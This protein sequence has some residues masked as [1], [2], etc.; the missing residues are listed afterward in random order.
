VSRVHPCALAG[1]ALPDEITTTTGHLAVL[2]YAAERF[3]GRLRVVERSCTEAE[4]A[5]ARESDPSPE[6]G[7]L[8]AIAEQHAIPV[9]I[10]SNNSEAAVR[11]FLERFEWARMIKT[12]ACRTPANIAQMKADPHL[13]TE[14]ARLVGIDPGACV[15]VG[16]SV[17]DVVAARAAGVSTVGLGKSP[18]R[19]AQLRAAGADAVLERGHPQI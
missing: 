5:C 2:R 1:V 18:R 9:A 7:G 14:A 10:V 4:V 17:S 19:A 6:I 15:L 8:L 16:D 3:P 11:V 12:L 13:V